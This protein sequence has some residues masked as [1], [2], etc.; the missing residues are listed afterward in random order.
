MA[1]LNYAQ[2]YLNE[3][4]QSWPY[5]LYFGALYATPNNGRYR[6]V[7]ANTIQIPSLDTT[8]RV[9]SNRDTIAFA[10]RNYNNAWETKTLRNER[11]WSTLL[12]PRDVDET[13]QVA[14]I[15]NITQV[16]NEEQKFPEMDMYTVSTIY[17]DW[18]TLGNTAITT[19]LTTQNILSVFDQ[20]MEKM[21]EARVP[22]TGRILYVN[23]TVNTKLKQAEGLARQ[24][25]LTNRSAE[26]NR[27]IANLDLVQIVEVPSNMMKTVYDFTVGAKPGS[28]AQQIE[29]F[30][31]HPLAVITPVTYEFAQLDAPSA[32]SNGKY[33][34]FEES[35]EDVFI[36]NKKA[37]GI[38]FVVTAAS[39]ESEDEEEGGGV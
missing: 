27:S 13:N 31:V 6:W 15:A 5:T 21:A 35:H 2:E 36:L 3:L 10:T 22:A 28:S 24:L 4:A 30:L 8:G 9:D 34:Y 19:A 32:M 26:V 29:M 7:N 38:D 23:P 20:M 1:A 11:Q 17:S 37:S 25:A 39:E 14:T 18:T 12:H 16:F 33:V